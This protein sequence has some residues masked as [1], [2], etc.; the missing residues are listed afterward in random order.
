MLEI[1]GLIVWLLF[2]VAITAFPFAYVYLSA[3]GGGMNK[4]EWV[5][6]FCVFL[7]AIFNWYKFFSLINITLG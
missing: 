4:V 3:L 2:S 5:A 1:I 7:V 6:V